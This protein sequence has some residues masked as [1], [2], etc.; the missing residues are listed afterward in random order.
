MDRY[1][2]SPLAPRGEAAASRIQ[3]PAVGLGR[4]VGNF[5][6]NIRAYSSAEQ[7]YR[8]VLEHDPEYSR[9]DSLYFH[10][11]EALEKSEKKAEALPYYERLV[12]EFEQSEYLQEAKRRIELLKGEGSKPLV[13]SL[14][15]LFARTLSMTL[16]FAG[17]ALSLCLAAV[18]AAA[19]APASQAPVPASELVAPPSWAY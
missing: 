3:G 19:Q 8:Y 12:E 14:S 11:A 9:R 13:G 16:R 1:P 7:R 15:R 17:C 4:A 2:N 6:L 10:L 5:Y 18:P